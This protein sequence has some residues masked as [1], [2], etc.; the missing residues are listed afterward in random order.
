MIK[1]WIEYTG[2]LRNVWPV[3]VGEDPVARLAGVFV[4]V[5]CSFLLRLLS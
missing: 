5:R 3:R 1:G 2:A 4:A